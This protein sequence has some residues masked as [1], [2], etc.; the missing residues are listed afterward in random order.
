MRVD[1]ATGEQMVRPSC[2][3]PNSHAAIIGGQMSSSRVVV[4]VASIFLNVSAA[5]AQPPET[6]PAA[7]QPPLFQ[8]IMVDAN[9][10]TVG[11]VIGISSVD[12]VVRQISGVW[13]L[14]RV[15]DLT[16][17]FD[18]EQ[19]AIPYFYQTTD[20]T[21]QA[22]FPVNQSD[23]RH[24]IEPVAGM[25]GMIDPATAPS[26]Y[27]AGTPVSV[28]AAKSVRNAGQSCIAF[29]PNSPPSIAVGPAQNVPVSSLEL[30]LP[31]SVK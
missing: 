5:V 20:C 17:G 3:V 16:I 28:V 31:F 2:H 15:R 19:D 8:G 10:K 12:L 23:D 7:P 13:V 21:G 25:V 29:N 22:Y 6:T 27:F 1:T 14:L 9:G 24:V 4:S 26:I 11:R 18:N 30:T